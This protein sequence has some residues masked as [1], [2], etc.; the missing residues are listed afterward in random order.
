MGVS[1]VDTGA[2]VEAT[3]CRVWCV[4][5]TDAPDWCEELL[6]EP[7]RARAES[8][9]TVVARRQFAAATALLKVAVAGWSGGDPFDVELR[10]ECPDCRRLH[11]RPEV[12]GGGPHVSLSHSGDL[13]A[14]ALCAHGPV[15]VDVEQ[16]NPDVDVDGML[17]FV[18]GESE[19]RV[20]SEIPDR[21]ARRRAFFQ[22]WTR[23]ESVL[24]ATGDGLRI[25]MSNVTLEAPDGQVR[26]TGFTNHPELVGTAQ[27]VDLRA[28][29]G[30][31]GAVT[32]LSDRPVRV[33]ELAG[34]DAFAAAAELV[35]DRSRI[36]VR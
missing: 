14:V 11:G 28:G 23:K 26:L 27:I 4:D 9:H 19:R 34:A 12:A 18:F 29:P 31:A 35:R 10:R 17:E 21:R 7:E 20:F 24:K 36:A 22:C 30:Y 3:D 16:V 8:F 15:G 6:S 13:V 1:G 33:W 32:V 2:A 5:P 25:P